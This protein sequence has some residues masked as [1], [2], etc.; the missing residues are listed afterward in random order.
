MGKENSLLFSQ[1]KY[2]ELFFFRSALTS[3]E[4]TSGAAEKNDE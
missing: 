3:H 1:M 4:M 2:G